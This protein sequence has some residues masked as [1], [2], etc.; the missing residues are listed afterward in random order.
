MEDGGAGG[1][2]FVARS[3]ARN[4]HLDVKPDNVLLD[5]SGTYKLGDF[6]VAYVKDKGWELQDGDGGYVAP[7]VLR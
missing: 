1:E 3:R 5:A 6:G 4:L 7:E 2:G